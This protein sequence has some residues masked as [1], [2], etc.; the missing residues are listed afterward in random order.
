MSKSQNQRPESNPNAIGQGDLKDG[1]QYSIRVS[2]S[3]VNGRSSRVAQVGQDGRTG[4][5][6]CRTDW[7]S[8]IN[9]ETRADW[10]ERERR[11][12]VTVVAMYKIVASGK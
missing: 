2:P 1:Q 10:A 7:S 12:A 8:Q 11:G 4:R 6:G 5:E 3:S 9:V